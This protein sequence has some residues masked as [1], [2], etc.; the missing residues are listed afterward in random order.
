MPLKTPSFDVKQGGGGGGGGSGR[1]HQ[2]FCGLVG[3]GPV[4]V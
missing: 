2:L 1:H 4:R 3:D